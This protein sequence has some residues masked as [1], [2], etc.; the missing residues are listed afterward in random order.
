MCFTGNVS[1]RTDESLAVVCPSWSHDLA[2]LLLVALTLGLTCHVTF[3]DA[4][5]A[6]L[7]S[8]TSHISKRPVFLSEE[9]PY[10]VP[11]GGL[12]YPEAVAPPPV[13]PPPSAD[14]LNGS[15]RVEASHSHHSSQQ[16]RNQQNWRRANKI[17][18]PTFRFY[19]VF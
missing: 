14:A 3:P 1:Y 18:S 8:T 11:T 7:E 10:S 4:L 17:K 12:S 19:N 6:D 2:W 16:V 5:L 15:S 13:P 9:T